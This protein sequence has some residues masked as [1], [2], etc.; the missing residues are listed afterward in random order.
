MNVHRKPTT[1][2]PIS[3]YPNKTVLDHGYNID[4]IWNCSRC[5]TTNIIRYHKGPHPLSGMQ[6]VGCEMVWNP[7]CQPPTTI[8]KPFTKKGDD[9]VPV[10]E[11]TG[12]DAKQVPYCCLCPFCG[13]THRAKK[14]DNQKA[15]L[16]KLTRF[17]GFGGKANKEVEI[18]NKKLGVVPPKLSYL[19]FGHIKCECGATQASYWS[20]FVMMFDPDY[21]IVLG[22]YYFV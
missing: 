14:L 21:H 15:Q 11:F 6:C 9:P 5:Q 10:V 22:T 3:F 20:R 13:R 17:F 4:G 1:Q 16:K 8:A 19:G 18:E 12:P 7:T 2:T